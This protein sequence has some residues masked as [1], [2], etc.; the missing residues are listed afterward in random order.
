MNLPTVDEAHGFMKRYCMPKNIFDHTEKVVKVAM[1]IASRFKAKDISLNIDLIHRSAML[2]DVFRFI[3]FKDIYSPIGDKPDEKTLKVWREI[4]EK[5][6]GLGHPEATYRHFK[7]AYPEMAT[8][9]RK[10]A[11][12]SVI[13]EDDLK[14]NTWEEK[15]LT[16]SDKRV[17]HDKIVSI[18][19]RFE[20]GHTRW[21]KTHKNIKSDLDITLIDSKYFELEKEIMDTIDL[22]PEEI[23]KL[24]D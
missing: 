3:D 4:I 6:D 1:F 13:A 22:D 11:Y 17:S 18:K 14:L 15:I 21:K 16:Y 12:K 10:H 23:N 8:V 19:D 20:E 9:I 7:A 5:Y 2:H 24:N